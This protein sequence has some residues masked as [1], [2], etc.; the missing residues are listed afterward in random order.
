MAGIPNFPSP[1]DPAAEPDTQDSTHLGEIG[2]HHAVPESEKNILPPGGRAF[3]DL[4]LRYQLLTPGTVHDFLEQA[5]SALHTYT[6]GEI[7]GADLVRLNHLTSYQLGR[8]LSG[9]TH[10]LVLGNHRILDRLGSGS[11][12]EVYVAEHLF[13]KRKV[14]IKVL[15]VDEDCPARV[16]ERFYSEM[17][18]LATLHHPHIVMAFDAGKVPPPHP[19]MPDML[20]LA[21]EL[22]PGGDLDQYVVDH[23]PIAVGQACEWIRQAAYGL[24]EAHDHQLIHRD[25]K[26]SNLLLTSQNQVKLVDFGLARQFSS[27]LTDPNALLGTVEFMSPE[28]SRD[29]SFVGSHAD[30]YGLGATLFFLLTGE[31]PYP[32]VRS[33]SEALRML[34]ETRPRRLRQLRTDTPPEL[35]LLI[36]R[37]LDPDPPRRPALPLTVM[38]A[39]LPFA[40]QAAVA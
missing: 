25:I 38:N 5:P 12:G 22:I 4:L 28:Q 19:G 24:Q 16:L 36:D 6:D 33:L 37:M 30:I 31:P 23:G 27:R 14:A 15:P 21:M 40:S 34:Q 26:P 29:P 39:L 32:E 35:D 20:Y 9:K 13:M 1:H 10:G 3:L 18:V 7:L 2:N 11:M 8:V 17:Q